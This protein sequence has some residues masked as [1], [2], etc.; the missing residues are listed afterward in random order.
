MHSSVSGSRAEA[1]PMLYAVV[2]LM[3]TARCSNPLA[4]GMIMRVAIFEP[5]PDCPNSKTRSGS[6]TEGED[7]ILDPPQRRD[8]IQLTRI[9]SVREVFVDV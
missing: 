3:F 4:P 1:G 2:P 8:E 5:P 7:I 6:P 9:R